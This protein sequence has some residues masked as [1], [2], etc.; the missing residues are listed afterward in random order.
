MAIFALKGSIDWPLGAAMALGS[1]AG[2]V[3]GARLA[4]SA[5]AKK[6]IFRLLVTVITAEL[7]HIGVSLC[8]RAVAAV[9]P[10]LRRDPRLIDHES[11]RR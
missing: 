10:C 2:G 5:S 6:W 7:V 1:I 11:S 4:S 9:T 3:L 8:R